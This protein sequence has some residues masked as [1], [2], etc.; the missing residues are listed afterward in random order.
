MGFTG[1]MGGGAA[2]VPREGADLQ[3]STL[4]PH[5]I[6][7]PA[8]SLGTFNGW[9]AT[10]VPA[11]N[12][13]A[14]PNGTTTGA[15]VIAD[16]AASSTTITL[17]GPGYYELEADI[18]GEIETLGIYCTRPLPQLAVAGR[19]NAEAFNSAAGARS[20][21]LSDSGGSDS[22]AHS[23]VAAQG[24]DGAPLT[25]TGST[26]ASP[27]WTNPSTATG[28]GVQLSH[29]L[30]D[31]YGRVSVFA[32]SER[33]AGA[34]GGSS[35]D[36]DANTPSILEL[37]VSA[38]PSGTT[39]GSVAFRGPVDADGA[40][41]GGADASSFTVSGNGDGSFD[42][43]AATDLTEA[44]RIIT[45][46]VGGYTTGNIEIQTYPDTATL[47]TAVTS[48]GETLWRHGGGSWTVHET[49]SGQNLLGIDTSEDGNLLSFLCRFDQTTGVDTAQTTDLVTPS[50]GGNTNIGGTSYAT[51][52]VYIDS[53]NGYAL[54]GHNN[55][56]GRYKSIADVLAD[57]NF[58]SSVEMRFNSGGHWTGN[59]Y[60]LA[61]DFLTLA[62]GRMLAC[63]WH[64]NSGNGQPHLSTSDTGPGGTWTERAIGTWT[65]GF[66]RMMATDGTLIVVVGGSSTWGVLGYSA[67]SGTTWATGGAI[68][69]T[70]FYAVACKP[71][72][73]L[74]V[75]VG[76]SGAVATTADPTLLSWDLRTSGTAED[77]RGVAWDA[78]AGEFVAV[79][80]TQTVI[81]SS[82]GITWT[83]ETLPA[84]VN[85][86]I[87]AIR[88]RTTAAPT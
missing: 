68:A 26:T 82:D 40:T 37:N 78:S 65:V 23:T 70:N 35:L 13:P 63:G 33:I 21:T 17:P 25:V 87:N 6:A 14:F 3:V 24:S 38:S 53:V 31:A 32:Y 54:T 10:V 52:T 60:S 16:A 28:D 76:A 30:T 69:G 84:G 75:A 20:A 62:S 85:G 81:T 79:G 29:V 27:S 56:R 80:T 48:D 50:W 83:A 86:T 61:D 47:L 43:V 59:N 39:V 66:P 11:A 19:T 4:G 73:S 49:W 71:D 57:G 15:V 41:L 22:P 2:I 9:T 1:I 34:G 88:A 72:G 45:A 8:G 18:G 64:W 51:Q 77:L 67:D 58:N 7:T 46:T 5:A 55:G 12:D 44:T 42:I 36:P 74:W